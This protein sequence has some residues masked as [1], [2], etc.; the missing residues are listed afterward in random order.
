MNVYKQ[1][2]SAAFFLMAMATSAVAQNDLRVPLSQPGQPGVLNLSSNFADEIII[3]THNE[4]DVLFVIDG[5]DDK[6]DLQDYS[7]NGLRRISRSGGGLEVKENDNVVNVHTSA[8]DDDDLEIW[9][10]VN[11]SIK[12]H[13]N[14]GDVVIDGVNGQHEITST[15]GDVEMTNISG[16]CIVNSVNGDIEVEM[17][18][19]DERAPMS[20]T[21]LNGDIEVMLPENVK[22]NGK[23]KTDFGDVYTNFDIKIDRTASSSEVSDRDGTYT[24]VINKWISGTVNGGGP[25][26]LFKTL[27]GDIEIVKNSKER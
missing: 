9:V 22:F 7:R 20:F 2:V 15:N 25:E 26:Y 14:H 6:D 5:D 10:P 11:F 19:V 12:L 16:A 8:N 21:G 23:M 17:V 1:I 24:V 27:H 13:T 18:K 4:K 3:R